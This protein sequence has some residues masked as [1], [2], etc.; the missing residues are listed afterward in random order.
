ME[1][2]KWY[3]E[4]CQRLYASKNSLN[5]HNRNFHKN[6]QD[7]FLRESFHESV[8]I[9]KFCNKTY[10]F[11]QSK[12]NHQKTCK[13]KIKYETEE[14]INLEIK[15][16]E[17]EKLKL[18]LEIQ[19]Q[20]LKNNYKININ[21]I[22]NAISNNGSINIINT[23]TIHNTNNIINNNIIINFNSYDDKTSALNILSKEQQIK[24]MKEPFYDMIPRLVETL[25]NGSYEEKKNIKIK[26]LKDKFALVFLD[27][28]FK[29]VSKEYAI[30]N[31]FMNSYWNISDIFSNIQ[32]QLTEKMKR[33]FKKLEDKIENDNDEEEIKVDFYQTYKS[34]K[35]YNKE[36]I[37]LHIYNQTENEEINNIL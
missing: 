10:K 22:E 4:K 9:C 11:K 2:K 18:E 33:E 21:N 35:E 32:E 8:Y 28:F 23:N 24:I 14:Q 27:G 12:Y 26:N 34:L 6:V 1:D 25:Y 13:E 36:K 15:K 29:C 31:I 17:L 5:N 37:L 7:V 20:K 3:C 19:N 30:T 16:Y